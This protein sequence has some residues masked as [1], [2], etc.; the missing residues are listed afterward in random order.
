[1][2]IPYYADLMS[3][4]QDYNDTFM[5]IYRLHTSDEH[6]IDIIFEKI[7]RNLVEPKI[8]SPTDIMATISNISKYNNRYYKSYYSLFKKLYEEYRPTKVPDI[9]FAFD[10]FA[11]KDY[12]VILEKYKDLNTDFKWFE[13]DQVSLD[14]HE[15]N[16]IYRSIINDDVDSLITFTRKFWFN[17]KQLL[18]S[19]FYP[20]SPLSLLE[21]CCNY[22]S[23]RCF[24][25]L[26]T[27]FK[28]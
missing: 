6:E 16:T 21:I 22:G 19:D 17:S 3:M 28:S 2:Y 25:F 4:N 1:M 9:T 27:K 8:F 7:K 14:I 11:Y 18:S 24:T 12:G 13:S 20:T 15:D 5:S 10:Y 23:I 26:R